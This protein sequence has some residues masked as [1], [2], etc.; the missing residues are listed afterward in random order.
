MES[1]D[2]DFKAIDT[3]AF[4]TNNNILLRNLILDQTNKINENIVMDEL[5]K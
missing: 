1:N 3:K 2:N 4:K 5:S